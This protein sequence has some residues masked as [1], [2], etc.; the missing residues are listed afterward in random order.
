MV[1]SRVGGV[2]NFADMNDPKCAE[3]PDSLR[4]KAQRCFNLAYET[5]DPQVRDVLVAYGHE[6]LAH[7]NTLI[8]DSI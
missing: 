5:N 2:V 8:R 7:A 6:L 4:E 1:L 3:T